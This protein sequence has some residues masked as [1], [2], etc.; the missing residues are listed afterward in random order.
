MAT[1][2]KVRRP[3]PETVAKIN[4]L[5]AYLRENGPQ[6]GP[7]LRKGLGW[8]GTLFYNTMLAAQKQELVTAKLL[9]RIGQ[10]AANFYS[11]EPLRICGNGGVVWRNA[12][13]D[14]APTLPQGFNAANP[15]GLGRGAAA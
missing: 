9:D 13:Q 15:F 8:R 2:P 3:R 6:F 4:D 14:D 5:V 1:T 7:E 12:R 10:P 11:V